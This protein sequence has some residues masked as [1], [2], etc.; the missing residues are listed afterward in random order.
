V[1]DESTATPEPVVADGGVIFGDEDDDEEENLE[2]M[3]W[4]I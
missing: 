3:S 1:E 4:I 2:D